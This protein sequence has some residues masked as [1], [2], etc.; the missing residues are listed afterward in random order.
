MDTILHGYCG[1][2]CGAC[3]YMLN[4]KTGTGTEQCYGCKSELP[5]GYCATCC[6]R[7]K[8][9]EFC[10]ECADLGACEL[11]EKFINDAN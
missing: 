2:F 5:A 10:N 11:M 8:G 9:Y 3:P 4:T 7:S 6:A 1:P